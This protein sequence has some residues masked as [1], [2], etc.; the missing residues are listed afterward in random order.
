MIFHHLFLNTNNLDF[1]MIIRFPNLIQK[2]AW[3][4]KI[5]VAIYA[6]ISGYGMVKAVS[7]NDK[8]TFGNAIKKSIDRYIHLMRKYWIVL[9]AFLTLILK[10]VSLNNLNFNWSVRHIVGYLIGW[11]IETN[12]AWWYIRLYVFF[13]ILFPLLVMIGAIIKKLNKDNNHFKLICLLAYIIVIGILITFYHVRP[14]SVI[15]VYLENNFI[16]EVYVLIFIE[17]TFIAMYDVFEIVST[18]F[19]EKKFWGKYILFI[20]NCIISLLVG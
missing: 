6:F 9:V 10:L 11:N 20:A 12:T 17:G 19:K 2:L 18:N 5:C 1:E 8:K 13:L 16:S 4:G 14:F 15:G 3:F 7:A